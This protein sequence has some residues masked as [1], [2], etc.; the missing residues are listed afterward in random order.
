MLLR[1]LC[2]LLGCGL[3]L[4][5]AEALVARFDPFGASYH[6]EVPYF[7]SRAIEFPP[8]AIRPE[9]R[10]F[11][12]RP[13]LEIE[14]RRFRFCS[15]ALG[16]RAARPGPRPAPPADRPAPL[17]VLCLGDSVTLC[18]GVDHEQGWPALLEAQGRASDGRAL[19][20]HNAGHL[21][22][23]TIQAADL[24][25]ALA[26]VLA[27]E[28]VLLTV[29][30]NDLDDNWGR[31]QRE[32]AAVVAPASAPASGS[33][34]AGQAEGPDP[35]APSA[36]VPGYR[37]F[38]ERLAARFT[39]A[40]LGVWRHLE[41]RPSASLAGPPTPVSELPEYQRGWPLAE[42]ALERLRAAC[43][44][45]GARLVL[46]DHSVPKLPGYEDWARRRGV[47]YA[48]VNFT[49]AEWA[50]PVRLSAADAHSNA[51]GNRLHAAHVLRALRAEG[52]LAP[53]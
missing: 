22:Y 6:R 8:E 14:L 10:L 46:L 35:L 24:F 27:P 11:Q 1:G 47:P 30:S 49:P 52:L 32:F 37:L 28:L 45:S 39:P 34:A 26:P 31:Y 13:N 44:A 4:A 42:A 9:G 19:E 29:V 17:R 43:E 12:H 53:E 41:S 16:H 50:Q 48:D 38:L 20:V 25:T 40:L 15:D 33:G 18:W 2:L 5:A 21:I 7:L 36:V 23:N 51:L 3:G